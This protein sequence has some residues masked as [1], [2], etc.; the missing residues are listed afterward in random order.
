MKC[1]FALLPFAQERRHLLPRL[2]LLSFFVHILL[3]H[4]P[5]PDRWRIETAL[6]EFFSDLLLSIHR[7]NNADSFSLNSRF[8]DFCSWDDPSAAFRQPQLA[9]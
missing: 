9:N 5:L 3:S 1:Q 4:R 8:P 7:S 2:G 6:I